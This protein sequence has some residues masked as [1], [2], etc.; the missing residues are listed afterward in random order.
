MA[1]GKES[2][3]AEMS[4]EE[5]KKEILR[6]DLDTK[7]L[8]LGR[9]KKDNAAFEANEE[10][11][12]RSNQQRMNELEAGRQGRHV[13]IQDC[14]HRS[15]GGPTNILHGGGIGSFSLITRAVLPDGVTLF[16]QCPRC[17]LA[18]YTPQPKTRQYWFKSYEEELAYYRKLL[19]QSIEEGIQFNE[20]RGPTFMFK[21]EEGVPIVPKRV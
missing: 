21:N 2:R 12:H 13:I 5:I 8:Q 10:Q 4:V 19:E 15:G 20:T 18:L 3:A 14:R 17:R 1:N 7:L 11:R 6:V 9:A 16:L